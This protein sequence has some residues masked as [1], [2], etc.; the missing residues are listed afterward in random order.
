MEKEIDATMLGIQVPAFILQPLVDNAVK[1]G[2]LA[3]ESGG[4]VGLN[5]TQRAGHMEICVYDDGLGIEEKV[6]EKILLLGYG[7]GTGVGLT[8]VNERLKVLY[9]PSYALKMESVP[10]E[11]TRIYLRIPVHAHERE[12]YHA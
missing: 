10:G 9:G 11:G 1:H 2:L 3:R 7:K 6:M 12:E 5:I 4:M 8:N